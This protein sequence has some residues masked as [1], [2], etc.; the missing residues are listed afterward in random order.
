VSESAV[1]ISA[2]RERVTRVSAGTLSPLRFAI[3]PFRLF[4]CPVYASDG[5]VDEDDEAEVIGEE[6]RRVEKW[7]TDVLR[8]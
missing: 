7:D 2:V 3:L 4:H 6:E 1:L 5:R 8:S